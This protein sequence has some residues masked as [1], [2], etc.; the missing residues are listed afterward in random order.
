ADRGRFNAAVEA[1]R[2]ALDR[3]RRERA[4]REAREAELAAS[5]VTKSKLCEAVESIYGE[6]TLERIEIAR[7]EWEGLPEDPDAETHARFRAQFEESCRKAQTRHENRQES[8]KTNAR[9]EEL[10]REAEPLAA[11]EDSPAYAWDAVSKEW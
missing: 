6:D 9:L 5:R 11:Q 10:S 3:E 7:S 8:A 1:A 2:A 4:E